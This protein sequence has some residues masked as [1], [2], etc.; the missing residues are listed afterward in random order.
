MRLKWSNVPIPEAHIAGIFAGIILQFVYPLSINWQQ[1]IGYLLGGLAIITGALL[2][3]WAVITAADLEIE[4]PAGILTTGPYTFSRNPMYVGWTL[5]SLGIALVA[6]NLWMLLSLPIVIL[7]THKF[8]I[9]KE[10]QFLEEEFGE[11]YQ[12]Y[13][14]DV[15]R[16]L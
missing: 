2:A 12:D 6:N 13:K 5:V 11:P 10:E 4:T 7:Y 16:Y 1:W 14:S 8:V 9:L 15:R 3:G